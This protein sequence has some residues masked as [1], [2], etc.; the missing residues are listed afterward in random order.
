MKLRV[1]TKL[2][3]FGL[4][5]MGLVITVAAAGHLGVATATGA[6]D[7]IA[8]NSAGLRHHLQANMMHQGIIGDVYASLVSAA[9]NDPDAIAAASR[10]FQTDAD[11][12]RAELDTVEGLAMDA[13]TKRELARVR[14]A[15]ENYV[16]T[17]ES[18][19]AIAGDDI[20]AALGELPRID[21]A[22][23]NLTT[24]LDGLSDLITR[25][26]EDA[27]SHGEAVSG[28]ALTL[29]WLVAAAAFGVLM[30]L[31]V[32]LSGRITR[33]LEQ[34]VRVARAIAAGD[35]NSQ[36][37]VTSRDETGDMLTALKA[38]NDR[39]RDTVSEVCQAAD[40]IT[41]GAGEMAFGNGELSQRTEE[42]AASLVQT[43]S[44]MEQMTASVKA[45]AEN[46]ARAN[47]LATGA[48]DQAATGGTVVH[49]AVAAMGEIDDASKRI[50]E[51]IGMVAEIAFQTN[52]LALNAAVEA[53]RAGEHG[54]GFAVVASEVR[55]L[56]Q[57]AASAA[58]EIKKLIEDSVGKVKN[59]S[60]LVAESGQAL[61]A[62]QDS[63]ARVTEIVSEIN[64][65]SQEQATGIDQVNRAITQIDAATQSNAALVEEAAATSEGLAGQARHLE[66]LMTFF[67]VNTS[68]HGAATHGATAPGLHPQPAP[69]RTPARKV[70][71]ATGF[72]AKIRRRR[73][74]AV[75]GRTAP[76]PPVPQGASMEDF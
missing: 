60:A 40:A 42:Q 53:A 28:T 11:T 39:L 7:R 56:A 29:V 15:L 37:E 67:K 47:K 18:I 72:A 51:I 13:E 57:R 54:R 65:S 73:K 48:R 9:R 12:L 16:A 34:A 43:A 70:A 5:G 66:Q 38:M 30:S 36:V 59:G 52:L 61:I 33:P 62:I 25:A 69:T 10:K 35:L 26:N 1:K 74:T 45:T 71:P 23:A 4:I 58:D 22:F 32:W 75:A 63:V 21:A 44:S 24:Q 68:T 6:M 27:L 50:A 17:A 20:G 49:R 3:G 2:L 64:A 55:N 46:A 14:P 8:V 19:I 76:T 41:G 31:S